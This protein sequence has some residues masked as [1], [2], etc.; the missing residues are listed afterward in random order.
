M[1]TV[2]RVQLPG[3]YVCGLG[4]AFPTHI[5]PPVHHHILSSTEPQRQTTSTIPSYSPLINAEAL[6]RVV[7]KRVTSPR[8]PEFSRQ[9]VICSLSH[10]DNILLTNTFHKSSNLFSSTCNLT[11]CLSCSVLSTAKCYSRSTFKMS[12]F[13]DSSESSSLV[14]PLD[15]IDQYLPRVEPY[16]PT[17]GG[18]PTE[19]ILQIIY[20]VPFSQDDFRSIALVNRR[21][22]RIMVARGWK[23]FRQIAAVQFPH[24]LELRRRPYR[25]PFLRGLECATPW[26]LED[27][28]KTHERF[29]KEIQLMSDIQASMIRED[30]HMKYVGVMGWKRNV[31]T[32]LHVIHRMQEFI[33][34]PTVRNPNRR[35]MRVEEKILRCKD[36]VESL[37]VSYCLAVRHT[38]LIV[39]EMMDFIGTYHQLYATRRSIGTEHGDTGAI[40]DRAMKLMFENDFNGAFTSALSLLDERGERKP[41]TKAL[42]RFVYMAQRIHS[43][44]LHM[45][46]EMLSEHN[47]RFDHHITRK[48]EEAIKDWY[49][50]VKGEGK[51]FVED[52]KRIP[53]GDGE[54]SPADRWR[55][56][57][58]FLDD[59]TGF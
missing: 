48:I 32:A 31:L 43:T 22:N 2:L 28:S 36:F 14:D 4:D 16:S 6:E 44:E 11:I 18:L 37:P 35:M 3:G 17:F 25:S 9:H 46:T 13:G 56:V 54:D 52:M 26:W 41:K 27:I 19:L 50:F 20:F 51:S 30:F 1:S 23:I 47:T 55:L 34:A 5:S 49:G 33:L 59:L 21:I 12:L 40:S 15:K 57:E 53:G 42:T 58:S 29:L 8:D 39:L 24:A 7:S 10:S 38:T 45:I